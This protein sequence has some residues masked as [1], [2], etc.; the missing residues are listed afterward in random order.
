[1]T[2]TWV[3]GGSSCQGQKGLVSGHIKKYGPP[4]PVDGLDLGYERESKVYPRFLLSNWAGGVVGVG[5]VGYG[6]HFGQDKPYKHAACQRGS[7]I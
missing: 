3:K 5:G 4:G 6:L 7:G 1:M 2:V